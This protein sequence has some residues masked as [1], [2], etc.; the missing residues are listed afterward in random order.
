[1]KQKKLI[2]YISSRIS[3]HSFWMMPYWLVESDKKVQE[4]L[5]CIETVTT[6]EK[7]EL[8]YVASWSDSFPF[9]LLISLF[10]RWSII[11]KDRSTEFRQQEILQRASKTKCHSF[12]YCWFIQ[13]IELN[14][15]FLGFD[16]LNTIVMNEKLEGSEPCWDGYQVSQGQLLLMI[17]ITA[18][19]GSFILSIELQWYG[20]Y[21]NNTEMG[22]SILRNGSD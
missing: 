5:M 19:L 15:A 4:C 13:S 2:R 9:S 1:M 3:Q 21:W 17:I 8:V 10:N 22:R 12:L 20:F 16:S 11:Y 18:Y 6:L 7:I 14:V